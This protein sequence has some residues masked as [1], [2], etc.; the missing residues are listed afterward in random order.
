MVSMISGGDL[1]VFLIAV[2]IVMTFFVIMRR[3]IGRAESD[4]GSGKHG[5]SDH[6]PH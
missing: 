4:P 1:L 2:F 5:R 6:Q 3:F